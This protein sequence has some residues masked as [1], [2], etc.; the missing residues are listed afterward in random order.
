MIKLKSLW[1]S[2]LC[3]SSTLQALELRGELTQGSLLRGEL[4]PGSA[5]WLNDEPVKVLPEGKFVVGFGRDA[6]QT[7][8]L[9]WQTPDGEV[10]HP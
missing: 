8:S 10:K 9:R 3:I 4:M 6:N 7:Q 5:V 1:F 2:L